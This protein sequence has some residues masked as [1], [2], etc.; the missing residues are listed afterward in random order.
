[1]LLDEGFPL[2]KPVVQLQKK[3]KVSS[4][5]MGKVEGT[6]SFWLIFKKVH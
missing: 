6:S 3:K 1:M 4:L 5:K 2:I